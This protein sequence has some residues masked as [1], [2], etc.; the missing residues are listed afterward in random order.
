MVLLPFLFYAVADYL[1]RLANAILAPYLITTHD[2]SADQIGFVTGAFFVGFGLAQFPMGIALD[3]YGPRPVILLQLVLAMLG[4]L[5]CF[6]ASEPW[7]LSLGRLLMGLGMAG[8]FMAAIKAASLWLAPS[9]MVLVPGLIVAMT[10]VGGMLGSGPLV[11]LLPLIPWAYVNL[12]LCAVAGAAALLVLWLVPRVPSRDLGRGTWQELARE[13]MSVF[14][15]FEFWALAPVAIA[16]A[17]AIVAYLT[18]W[19]PV[20]LRDVGNLT[21][22]ESAWVMFAAL[23]SLTVGGFVTSALARLCETRRWPLSALAVFGMLLS[24]AVQVGLANDG[25]PYAVGLWCVLGFLYTCPIVV[26][27]SIAREFEPALAARVSANLN[28]FVF[29]GT[30]AMQWGMGGVIE[31]SGQGQTGGYS[32]AGFRDAMAAVL[33]VQLGALAWYGATW[34]GVRSWRNR[35]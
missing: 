12:L 21:E 10:G 3:R 17:S 8:S 24:M 4:A 32:H 11:E 35:V 16:G 7:S 18:L 23:A 27:T 1:L 20:W 29:V 33:F 30:F 31:A 19:A 13:S 6:F 22:R 34:L 14:R 26:Y 15:R 5:V 28:L 9:Q 2:L 25:I